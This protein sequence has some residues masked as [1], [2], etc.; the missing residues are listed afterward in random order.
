MRFY[1]YQA[2]GNDYIVIPPDNMPGGLSAAEIIRICDRHYGVGSDGILLGPLPSTVADFGG[3]TGSH[4]VD[5]RKRCLPK[6]S[7]QM[8]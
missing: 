8:R 2:L 5:K 3:S 4:V 1:K 6:R 7:S